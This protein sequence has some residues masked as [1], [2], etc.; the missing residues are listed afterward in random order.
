MTSRI[1]EVVETFVKELK[2]AMEADLQDRLLKEREMRQYL[3]ERDR[4]VS[5]R[6]AAWKAELS[7]REVIM[8]RSASTI[9]RCSQVVE[10]Q[11]LESHVPG[12]RA[13]WC[14]VMFKVLHCR[15]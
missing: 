9:I 10:F 8:L 15:S 13:L 2:V 4:E 11:K 7:R 6:E 1:R 12:F 3:E 14:C 5:E